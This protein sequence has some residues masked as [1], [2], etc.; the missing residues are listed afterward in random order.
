MIGFLGFCFF[1]YWICLIGMFGFLGVGFGGICESL[2]LWIFGMFGFLDL[3]V[4]GFL[5]FLDTPAAGAV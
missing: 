1:Y 2:D 5:E 3:W 4:W